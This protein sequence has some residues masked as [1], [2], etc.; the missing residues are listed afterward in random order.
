MTQFFGIVRCVD[1]L[2]K[3]Y[4]QLVYW[5]Q[6]TPSQDE[7]ITALAMVQSALQRQESRGTHFNQ[8]YPQ[9]LSKSVHS[10]IGFNSKLK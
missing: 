3:L 7:L 1:E 10:I 9:T 4:I 2:K 6:A 5:Y 8:D